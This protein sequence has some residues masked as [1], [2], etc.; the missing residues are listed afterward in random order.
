M[1]FSPTVYELLKRF[2]MR[3]EYNEF[4]LNSSEAFRNEYNKKYN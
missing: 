2:A 1:A 3:L 4:K